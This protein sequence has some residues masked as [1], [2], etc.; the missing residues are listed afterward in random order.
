M[1]E[2]V[3]AGQAPRRRVAI[4]PHTHW[5][6]EWHAPFQVSRLRLAELLDT[7]LSGLET[8]FLL[9]GQMAIVDDY[10]EVRPAAAD[11]V[12][13]L[14][15]AG[16]LSLGPWYVLPD[17]FLVSGETLVR[18]LELGLRRAAELGGAMHVG[19]LPDMF[20]HVA[21]MPQ[22]LRLAGIEHAVVWRGV[23]SAIERTGFRWSAPDGSTVRAEYL[24]VGYANGAFLPRDATLL[25]ERVRTHEDELETYWLGDILLM[26][27]TDHSTPAPGLAAALRD[28]NAAQDEYEF[29]TMRLDEYLSSA[30][31]GS[32]PEWS[33]EMRSG[34]RANLLMG[35]LSNRVDLKQ[36]AAETERILERVA[37]PLAALF[38]PADRWPGAA[39][40]LAWLE[41]IRNSAHDSIAGCTPGEIADAVLHRYREARQIGEAVVDLALAELSASMA[42]PGTVVVNPSAS[43]RGGIVELVV[44]S[45]DVSVSEERMR[46]SELPRVL[47]AIRNQR[48]EDLAV[49]SLERD[50]STVVLRLAAHAPPD[51]A[52]EETKRQ[53]WAEVAIRS[54]DDLVLRVERSEA[55]IA[56]AHVP[57][58]PGYGWVTWQPGPLAV[59]TVTVDGVAM[60]N[61]R[62]SLVVDDGDGTFALDG[63]SGLD[64]LV[65]EADTGDTYNAA[66]HGRAQDDPTSVS[67]EVVEDGPIR[68]RLRVVRT[69]GPP[70]QAAVDTILELRAGE[71]FVRVETTL[72]NRSDDHRLRVVFPLPRRARS[73]SA[74]CAFGVVERGLSAEGS[75]TERGLPTF[76]SRRFV[77][78]GG[79]TV[80][81]DGLLEYEVVGDGRA[82]ALTLLRSTGFLSRDGNP[83][84]TVPAGPTIE[85]PEAQLHGRRRARYVVAV[86]DVDPYR[87]AEDAFVPLLVARSHGGGTRPAEGQA[88]AVSGGEV[89]A[90]RRVDGRLELRAFNASVAPTRVTIDGAPSVDLRPFEIVTVRLD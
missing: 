50:G 17:E 27:G 24:P 79:L 63:V 58:V 87:L 23:P 73:S 89:S 1:T 20:G 31:A 56:L 46:W 29:A 37:E 67:V 59:P 51:T 68:G 30:P 28:A 83:S 4:V 40:D 70:L 19:Y 41:V 22:L 61:G 65:D 21:Q 60:T 90:L 48:Y 6:R 11:R 13:E 26:N 77:S 42:E 82:L 44:D 10:L 49:R 45:G 38:L 5:D 69:Y 66:P 34:A 54:D 25:V 16:V 18:N 57:A 3:S 71:P 53:L 76:P 8:P 14:N 72:E 74:E 62:V 55:E 2:G 75:A 84:R 15:E 32:L 78:A 86:G 35:V 80:A 85:V 9:D 36:A 43:T 39:L 52:V 33:G 47:G 12:R 64:R 88:L 81:H 7:V